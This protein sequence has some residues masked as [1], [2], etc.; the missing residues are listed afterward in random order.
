MRQQIS[1]NIVSK[2]AALLDAVFFC[3][4]NTIILKILL[5]HA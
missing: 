2:K 3:Y 5:G 4:F 1:L